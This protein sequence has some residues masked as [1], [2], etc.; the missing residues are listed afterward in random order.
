VLSQHILDRAALGALAA[1]AVALAARSARTLTTSGA[2]AGLVAG[3]ICIAAGWSWGF[4]LLGLFVSGSI[5]SK[6]GE[7]RKAKMAAP[8]VAKGGERDAWQVAA[9]GSVYAAAASCLILFGGADWF[10]V[11]IGALAAST[12]DTWSTEI[13]TMGGADPRLIVSGRRVP[14]GTSGGLT[15]SGTL[16]A[17]A[18][19]IAVAVAARAAAWPVGFLAVTAAGLA[20]ALGDSLLGAT[21]QCK[22]WCEGCKSS[23]ERAVHTCG[24]ATI[25]SGGLSWLN[26]DGVNFVSTMIG[27]LV[28]LLLSGFGTVR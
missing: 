14:A 24:A 26:N 27:G 13:G 25:R 1:A 8:V 7:E 6:M 19:S 11:G 17:V 3:T 16:G 5:L 12:A 9:N 22:L 4:L 28:A 18:G 23:T 21:I 20:G 10:A 2:I 15:M